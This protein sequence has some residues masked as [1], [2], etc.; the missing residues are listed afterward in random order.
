MD[1][2][3]TARS[4]CDWMSRQVTSAG[5]R[6]IVFGIS[7]G[8]DSAVLAGLAMRCGFD[9][10]IGVAMPCHS[11]P[12]DLEHAHD[13]ARA[14]SLTITVCD[15]SHAYDAQLQ[16]MESV[17]PGAHGSSPD[18]VRVRLAEA[19][20][21]PRLRMTVL[22][23]YANKLNLLVAGTTNRSEL[24]VGYFTKHGDGGADI[25]PIAGLVK[26]EV[27]ELAR[28]LGV[29]HHIIDKPPTAGLWAG[30]TDEGEMGITYEQLDRYILTGEGEPHVIERVEALAKASAHKMSRP[31]A[32]M[33]SC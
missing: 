29:P 19:N 27:R 28:Y 1:T 25:I 17:M 23:Y 22:Y 9:T 2:T 32:P 24:K 21:K 30:Q 4:I 26:S 11:D 8:L 6:G 20:V 14:F 12:V 7:G 13:C 31:A 33:L 16:L 18:P 10:C 15:L 5:A 3:T